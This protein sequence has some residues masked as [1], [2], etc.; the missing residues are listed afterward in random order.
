MD[1]WRYFGR[2]SGT[3]SIYEIYRI[4]NNGRRLEHQPRNQV[5][6]LLENGNW[7]NDPEDVGI[8]NE[9]LTGD[10]C[11]NSDEISLDQVEQLYRTWK[12]GKWPGRS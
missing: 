6:R 1:D 5:C 8:W 4:P 2:T 3:G 7:I 10:F 11:E 9:R 12:Q